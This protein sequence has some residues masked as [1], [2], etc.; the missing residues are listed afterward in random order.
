ME[1]SYTSSVEFK[2]A[3]ISLERTLSQFKD[4]AVKNTA[5]MVKTGKKWNPRK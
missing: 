3:K 2:C 1:L 4:L 5:P